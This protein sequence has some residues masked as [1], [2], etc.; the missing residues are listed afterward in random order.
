MKSL[1]TIILI[2]GAWADGSSWNTVTQS[3]QA[4]GY[5]VIAIQLPLTSLIEDVATVRRVLNEQTNPVVLVGHSYGGAVI[6]KMTTADPNIAALVYIA[7]FAPD[8]G[9]SMKDLTGGTPQPAGSSAIHPDKGG[10]LWLNPDGFVKFFAADVDPTQ[11][12]VM[13][14]AQKPIAANSLLGEEKFGP[15]AWKSF[16][17]W[18]LLSEDD[19]MI[20]PEAQRFMAQRAGAAITSIKAS[21]VPMVSHPDAVTK[22]I[23]T[24]AQSILVTA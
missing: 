15:P 12:R 9:E 5:K 8:E 3:L 4:D 2:H 7:A 1:P 6:T 23:E 24:A 16:P 14:A 17:A 19:Q 20:P 10:F 18:Y 22:I 11:A 13:A 21:H